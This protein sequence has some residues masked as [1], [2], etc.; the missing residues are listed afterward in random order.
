M[1]K[2][3]K[4]K[5]WLTLKRHVYQSVVTLGFDAIQMNLENRRCISNVYRK[6]CSLQL[7][8]STSLTL[9]NII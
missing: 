6:K 2:L 7:R 9:W 1:V 5:L 8:I 4:A 3:P